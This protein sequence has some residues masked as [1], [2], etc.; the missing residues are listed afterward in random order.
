MFASRAEAKYYVLIAI[1]G[2]IVVVGAWGYTMVVNEGAGMGSALWIAWK[3][4][5]AGDDAPDQSRIARFVNTIM[6]IAGMIVTVVVVTAYTKRNTTCTELR[7]S[8]AVGAITFA[9]VSIKGTR[10]L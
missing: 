3:A 9:C 2:V 1:T 4:L 7:I 5:S 6:V 10:V 8:A